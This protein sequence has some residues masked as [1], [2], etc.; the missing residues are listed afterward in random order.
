MLTVGLHSGVL[1]QSD[2]WVLA[3]RLV[4]VHHA[5]QEQYRILAGCTGVGAAA[6]GAPHHPYCGCG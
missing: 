5:V 2:A 1:P 4:T 3:N 6:W